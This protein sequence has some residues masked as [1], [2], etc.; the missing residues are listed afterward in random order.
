MYDDRETRR[1]QRRA[2]KEA[3]R[4]AKLEARNEP[5]ESLEN[6][7]G[8][9][10]DAAIRRRVERRAK[11]RREFFGSLT[12]FLAVNFT[13]WFIWYMS[14]AGKG[15]L[16]FPWP[17]FITIAWAMSSDL[18]GQGLRVY[19]NTENALSRREQAIQ[20]EIALEKMR[21][22]LGSS[23]ES[24]EKPKRDRLVRLSDD[25]ELLSEEDDDTVP[26]AKA[27]NS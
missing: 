26:L 17:I 27:K 2:D 12:S 1:A 10:L 23:D 8:P 7:S 16:E 6:L 5:L 18:V 21:L 24:Y 14:S 20:R 4:A 13:L 25:G 11:Q 19:Q 9:E 22:G 3:R 15:T